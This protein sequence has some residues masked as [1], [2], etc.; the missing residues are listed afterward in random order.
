MVASNI[1]LIDKNFVTVLKQ[2]L[3]AQKSSKKFLVKNP[4]NICQ[5]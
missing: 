2:E 4:W 1:I 5:V 3:V